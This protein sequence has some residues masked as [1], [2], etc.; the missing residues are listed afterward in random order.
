MKKIPML[1][2]F[3]IF[4]LLGCH[5]VT[6]I[7]ITTDQSLTTYETITTDELVSL[8]NEKADFILY[9][10]SVSCSSCQAFEPYLEEY[11]QETH[12]KVYQ[13]EVS[14]DFPTDNEWIP[15]QFTPTI[16]IVQDGSELIKINE[17]DQEGPFSSVDDFSKFLDEYVNIIE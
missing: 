15:Y 1:F 7:D 9:I 6:P 4:F 16:V 17:Y 5:S 14:T 10:S 2:L 3:L 8:L 13:I 12:I 11:I